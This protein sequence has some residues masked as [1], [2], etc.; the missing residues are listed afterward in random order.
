MVFSTKAPATT[1]DK[2][3]LSSEKIYR[4]L[5]TSAKVVS[6]I[7]GLC[8][9]ALLALVVLGIRQIGVVQISSLL[10]IISITFI[11]GIFSIG[12]LN[13]ISL[14]ANLKKQK[15]IMERLSFVDTLDAK[16]LGSTSLTNGWHHFLFPSRSLLFVYGHE[17]NAKLYKVDFTTL[18]SKCIWSYGE[19][20]D[21][22]THFAQT[23]AHY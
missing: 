17:C 10:T 1:K 20:I 12:G 15:A 13:L 3:F 2:R 21:D 9:I 7:A 8:L 11:G 18:R 4:V 5:D 6:V 16:I 14:Q 23:A 19:Q 22:K